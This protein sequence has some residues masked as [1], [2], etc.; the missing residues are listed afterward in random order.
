[1]LLLLFTM[2]LLTPLLHGHFGTP[3]LTGLHV[4]L[5]QQSAIYSYSHSAEA[6]DVAAAAQSGGTD[7]VAVALEPREVDVQTAIG[8]LLLALDVRPVERLVGL[9]FAFVV[10][11]SAMPMPRWRPRPIR[12]RVRRGEARRPPAQAPP[13][14]A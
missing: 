2:Q 9:I 4:H 10:L 5:L 3:K 6:G 13:F 8:P 7:A 11:A 12:L 1:M 14:P